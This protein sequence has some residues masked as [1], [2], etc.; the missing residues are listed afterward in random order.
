MRK[1]AHALNLQLNI[2]LLNL[3]VIQTID[4]ILKGKC[5]E[6]HHEAPV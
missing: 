3:C 4:K 2:N 1:R 5:S 6:C